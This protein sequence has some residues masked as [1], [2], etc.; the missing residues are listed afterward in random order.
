MLIRGE[1]IFLTFVWWAYD[2]VKIALWSQ[3]GRPEVILVRVYRV[4]SRFV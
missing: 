1:N 3:Y 4:H 2:R